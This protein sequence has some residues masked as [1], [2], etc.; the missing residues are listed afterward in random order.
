MHTFLPKQYESKLTTRAKNVLTSASGATSYSKTKKYEISPFSLLIGLSKERGALSRN[1]LNSHKLA[2]PQLV[3]RL[4]R[5]RLIKAGLPRRKLLKTDMNTSGIKQDSTPVLTTDAKTVLKKA[6]QIAAEYQQQYIGTEHIL[7][8]LILYIKKYIKKRKN[9]TNLKLRL[10]DDHTNETL[11]KVLHATWGEATAKHLNEIKKHIETIFV[12]SISFPNLSDILEKSEA[13]GLGK[14]SFK[15]KPPLSHKK[16][17][18]KNLKL[19]SSTPSLDSFCGNLTMLA[20]QTKLD[21]VIGREK[22]ISRI[23][24][25]LSRRTKN[26]ALLIGEPGVGKTA[27]VQGL[28][29]RI[30]DGEVPGNL[31]SKKVYSLDLNSLIA[32]TMFRGDFES[33]M[34]SILKEAEKENVIL[35]IDE[36]HSIIGAGAAQGSMDVANILKPSLSQGK[37]HCIGATTPAEYRKYIEKER[38]LE[39]RF[40]TV[41]IAEETEVQST[42]TLRKLKKLYEEHH[43]IFI[44]DD[45]IKAAVQLSSRYIRDRFLPDKA[46]DVIDEAASKLRADTLNLTSRSKRIRELEKQKLISLRAKEDAVSKENYKEAISFKYAEDILNEKI[47][48]FKEN[49]S[50]EKKVH[51]KRHHIEDAVSQI[52]GV[53]IVRDASGKNLKELEQSLRKEIIGQDEAIEN[54]MHIL[55]RKEAGLAHPERPIGSLLFLGPTGVGKT[56]IA[57]SISRNY[58]IPLIKIDMSEYSEPHSLSR[59]IGSPPGYVGFDESGEL[60]EKVRR[61]PHSLV[62]FDEVEKAHPAV[63]KLLL[64]ILDE[65]RITDASGRDVSLKN[66]LIVLTANMSIDESLEEHTLGFS[67]SDDVTQNTAKYIKAA[68]DI[69]RPEILDR[70]NKIVTF[71]NLTE[72]DISSIT[73]LALGQLKKRFAPTKIYIDKNVENYVAKHAYK[74]RLGARLVNSAVEQLVE[75]PAIDHILKHKTKSIKLVVKRNK[76]CCV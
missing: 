14:S 7:Y 49:L 48:S 31:L 10:G 5:H 9:R 36:M 46:L 64:S 26:N 59:L 42:E 24:Y 17:R 15:N 63:H 67:N 37:L 74:P 2:Y 45:A 41:F 52:S 57:K 53:P 54:L 33:R 47:I 35:F 30:C 3:K 68:K 61:N 39:R 69:L 43:H 62:L 21:P 23:I 71:K 6:M 4:P 28:A 20:E 70:V 32:G 8:A 16:A 34:K 51:L 44:D 22:E 40:Q 50:Y 75:K 56:E 18:E 66:T 58:G 12:Q 76:I 55:K 73:K 60:T 25:I 13:G 65:G 72:K 29:Q 19:H 27:V 1:I 38:A 11:F